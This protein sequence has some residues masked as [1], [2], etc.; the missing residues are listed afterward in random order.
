MQRTTLIVR[1]TSVCVTLLI[2]CGQAFGD[3]KLVIRVVDETG[4]LLPARELRRSMLGRCWIQ[5][6]M[7]ESTNEIRR[8]QLVGSST[9]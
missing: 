1:A 9:A 5:I 6:A 3:G 8:W 4:K 2:L 7:G